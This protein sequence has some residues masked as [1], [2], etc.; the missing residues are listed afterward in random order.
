MTRR[1]AAWVA[2]YLG[3]A[4]AAL[5][6]DEELELLA[7]VVSQVD[8]P[9]GQVLFDV[10]EDPDG[11]WIIQSGWVEFLVGAGQSSGVIGLLG[12]RQCAGDLPLMLGT[13][14]PYR[15]RAVGETSCL[16]I[17]AKAFQGLLTKSPKVVLR[18]ATKVAGHTARVQGR[19]LEMLGRTLQQQVARVLLHEGND[20]VFPFSQEMCAAMLGVSRAPVNQVLKEFEREGLV[21]LGYRQIEVVNKKKLAAIAGRGSDAR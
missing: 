14:A 7:K 8:L 20:G 19:V 2:K 1:D 6:T 11:V 21:R 15:A 3:R 5:F 9:D 16:F 17:P 12:S 13:P 18:W 4:E 10:G